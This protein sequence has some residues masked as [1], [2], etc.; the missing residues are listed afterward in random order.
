MVHCLNHLPTLMGVARD[1]VG[2]AGHSRRT[3]Q[4]IYFTGAAQGHTRD[5]PFVQC[6]EFSESNFIVH[7]FVMKS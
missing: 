3:L 4:L 1:G 2:R 6:H 5:K 7:I